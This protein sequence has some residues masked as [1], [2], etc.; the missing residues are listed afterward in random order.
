MAASWTAA[1]AV[2]FDGSKIDEYRVSA[3]ERAVTVRHLGMK[4]G[5][6]RWTPEAYANKFGASPAEAI[7]KFLQMA[8]R[9]CEEATREWAAAEQLLARAQTRAKRDGIAKRQVILQLV[10]LWTRRPEP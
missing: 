6:G 10:E 2:R 5:G 1:W 7:E 4:S 8:Q 9:G 3:T